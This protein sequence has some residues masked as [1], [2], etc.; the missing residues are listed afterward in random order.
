MKSQD[1]QGSDPLRKRSSKKKR[2]NK[3]RWRLVGITAGLIAVIVGSAAGI[4]YARLNPIYHFSH[5]LTISGGSSTVTLHN[6]EFNL[7]LLGVDSRTPN[8]PARSDTIMLV[9]VNLI[10]HEYDILSIPRDSRVEIPP[11]GM[12]KITHANYLGDLKNG[13]PLGG[14]KLASQVVSNFT[15]LPINFY[16]EINHF[17]LQSLVDSIGTVRVY[18]P[19]NV[20]IIN[21]WYP[22]LNGKTIPRRIRH[23]KRR[24]GFRTGA[25]ARAF[26]ARRFFPTTAARGTFARHRRETQATAKLANDPGLFEKPSQVSDRHQHVHY[27]YAQPDR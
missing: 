17:G 2:K 8:S 9:H 3:K 20:P 1:S 25:S 16:A 7:L 11:Y 26:A 23:T 10:K 22:D 4:E 19:F 18:V 14:I 24:D 6:G 15:G 27:R 5:L 12:T 21:A 13:T